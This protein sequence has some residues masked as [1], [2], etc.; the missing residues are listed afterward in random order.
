MYLKLTDRTSKVHK[1]GKEAE[2][3]SALILQSTDK[4]TAILYLK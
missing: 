3:A 4:T 2:L 1:T